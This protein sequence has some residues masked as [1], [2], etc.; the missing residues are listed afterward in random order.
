[1][2]SPSWPK[3]HPYRLRRLYP[4][5]PLS[6]R[7]YHRR[8]TVMVFVASLLFVACS[9]MIFQQST[10]AQSVDPELPIGTPIDDD[11]RADL[12]D[13]PDSTNHYG[14][15]NTAYPTVLGQFPT[16]CE[17]SVSPSGPRHLDVSLIWLGEGKSREF[18]ADLMP[19]GD[20]VTNILAEGTADVA[21]QDRFCLLY[22]SDAADE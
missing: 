6:H 8:T 15:D 17:D 16:V 12:G 11:I 13:A 19:D 9:M 5:D 7:P 14:L 3:G 4:A 22:T 1:M 20:G 2:Q 21:D 18:D 10:H